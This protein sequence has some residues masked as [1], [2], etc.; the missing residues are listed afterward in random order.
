MVLKIAYYIFRSPKILLKKYVYLAI[1]PSGCRSGGGV[2]E[3]GGGAC[4]M[5]NSRPAYNPTSTLL[6][7]APGD[8]KKWQSHML[9]K[10]LHFLLC[11][12]RDIPT[13]RFLCDRGRMERRWLVLSPILSLMTL[14][15]WLINWATGQP[16]CGDQN[17]WATG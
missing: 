17:C 2:G 4:H 1:N 9:L 11:H 15:V 16:L 5:S 10:I 3:V 6:R 7:N 14:W 13:R 8:F 12:E